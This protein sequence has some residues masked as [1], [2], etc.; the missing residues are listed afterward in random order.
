[1]IGLSE[2]LNKE[3]FIIMLER[4]VEN[5]LGSRKNKS[6]NRKEIKV[7]CSLQIAKIKLAFKY[8]RHLK[9]WQESLGRH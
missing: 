7:D 3:K 2:R 6:F 5:S 1:M 4:I 8:G 9:H